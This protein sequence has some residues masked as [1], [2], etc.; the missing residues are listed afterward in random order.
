MLRI[1]VSRVARKALET[2][3][4]KH[5]RQVAAKIADLG[6]DPTPHDSAPLKGV[7]DYRRAEIGEYRL[8]YKVDGDELLVA[9]VGRRNDDAIYREFERSQKR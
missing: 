1:R 9:A 5:A 2:F 7:R 6:R 4:P 3:P 8:I